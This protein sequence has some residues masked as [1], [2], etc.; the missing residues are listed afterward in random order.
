MAKLT[1]LY[2]GDI[3]GRPGRRVVSAL[4]PDLRAKH[5]ADV[6]VAQA[7]NVTHGKGMS[8]AH[9]RELQKAGVD[10]FTGGNHTLERADIQPLL[11]DPLEPVLAPLNQAGSQL[12]WG[13]KCVHTPHGELRVISLLGTTFPAK[14]ELSANP[15]VAIDTALQM[16]G[17]KLTLVN[18]HGD[19]SSEKRVIGYYLAGRVSAVI[20]DHWHVPTADAM[21]LPG[22]TAHITD[23]GMCGTLHSSLGV[24]KEIIVSRWRDNAKIRHEIFEEPPYQLNAVLIEVDADTGRAL[25]IKHMHMQTNLSEHAV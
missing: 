2:L 25:S 11:A 6:V 12:A 15:L 20:G 18:F 9:M 19:L 17:P 23:V 7:E 10:V 8:A 14:V 3:M 24:T 4:L 13:D 5:H 1:I 21:V 16:P 22:G